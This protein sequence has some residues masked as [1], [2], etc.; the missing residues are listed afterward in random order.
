MFRVNL[1]PF[2]V[3]NSKLV[4][5]RRPEAETSHIVNELPEVK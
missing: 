5:R 2:A 3:S 4:S 1:T